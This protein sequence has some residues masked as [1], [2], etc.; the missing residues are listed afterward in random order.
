MHFVRIFRIPPAIIGTCALWAWLSGCGPAEGGSCTARTFACQDPGTALECRDGSWAAIPC[1]GPEG[2][3][4]REGAVQCDM[5]LN[6][7]GD[8]CPLHAEGHV[9]CKTPELDAVLEC[10]GGVLVETQACPQCAG[11]GDRLTCG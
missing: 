10:R 4:T 7:P 1:R 2:C 11:S 8:G 3:A 5:A 6:Q 9:T